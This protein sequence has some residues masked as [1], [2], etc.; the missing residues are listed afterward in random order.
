[1]NY[2]LTFFFK[3]KK[4]SENGYVTKILKNGFVVLIPKYGIEGIV[5]SSSS[6]SSTEPNI[7]YNAHDN[8]LETYSSDGKVIG[9]IKLFDKVAVAISV[10]DIVAGGASG[11]R[12]KLKMELIYPVVPGLSISLDD[13][14]GIDNNRE[15]SRKKRFDRS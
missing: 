4:E 2:T 11:M 15:N 6:S 1:L 5:Y 8:S 9:S 10:E 13:N 3:G 7:L 14:S 12:Q